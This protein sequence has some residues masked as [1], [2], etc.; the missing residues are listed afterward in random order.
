MRFSA[1]KGAVSHLQ[2]VG[3]E[4]V[5]LTLPGVGI[6]YVGDG[7]GIRLGLDSCTRGRHGLDHA[8]PRA[9]DAAFTPQELTRQQ[10]AA[11]LFPNGEAQACGD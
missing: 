7:D 8:R 5:S 11:F 1:P 10:A 6:A 4:K 2:V 9:I 3:V